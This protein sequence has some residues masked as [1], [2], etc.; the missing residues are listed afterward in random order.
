LSTCVN[1]DGRRELGM[2]EPNIN[3]KP[4]K[5]FFSNPLVGFMGS[6]ASL[7]GVAL[8]VYF[9]SLSRETPELVYS[10]YPERTTILLANE[11]PKL[12]AIY[13]ENVI[14]TD[15]SSAQVAFWNRGTKAIKRDNIIKPVTFYTEK[16]TP[17]LAATINKRSRDAIQL[18]L[19][20]EDIANGRITVSWN[21]LEQNDGAIIDLIYEGDHN[22]KIFVDGDIEAQRG[23]SH[24]VFPIKHNPKADKMEMNITN[25]KE[26]VEVNLAKFAASLFY[27]L[28][29][30]VD[31]VRTVVLNKGKASELKTNYDH[32]PITTDITSVRL[33]L[34]HFGRYSIKKDNILKPIVIHTQN[35]VP[36]LEASIIQKSRDVI[37]LVIQ[38]REAQEGR[39]PISWDI[40]ENSDF[41]IIELIYAGDTN[42]NIHI[43]GVVEGQREITRIDAKESE[44]IQTVDEQVNSYLKQNKYKEYASL[45]VSIILGVVFLYGFVNRIYKE[46]NPLRP[47]WSLAV[48]VLAC[49]SFFL[50]TYFHFNIH[51]PRPPFGF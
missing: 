33:L 36:I 7:I 14:S 1:L 5:N 47:L 16:S 19:N 25:A 13:S 8:S 18:I 37:N 34:Y 29:Y 3:R 49:T 26:G 24:I 39:V 22:I 46:E 41:V 6:V 27:G 28:V 32:R 10:V 38:T 15:I 2:V 42:V 31:P 43:D 4:V 50:W 44:A 48:L 35:H 20:K 11:T 9:Y 45:S 40:L 12:E 51:D 30:G 23:I 21:I 17:I